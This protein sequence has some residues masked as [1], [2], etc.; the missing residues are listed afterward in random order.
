MNNRKTDQ[1]L[2]QSR[3]DDTELDEISRRFPALDRSEINEIAALCEERLNMNEKNELYENHDP[4]TVETVEVRKKTALFRHPAFTAATSF[5]ILIGTAGA[6]IAGISRKNNAETSMSAIEPPAA[7]TQITTDPEESPVVTTGSEIATQSAKNTSQ[8][9]TQTTAKVTEKAVSSVT[10]TG[11]VSD[12]KAGSVPATEG[13]VPPPTEDITDPPEGPPVEDVTEPIPDEPEDP[14]VDKTYYIEKAK[15]LREA[16]FT[17]DQLKGRNIGFDMNDTFT[18]ENGD[19]WAKVDDERFQC[20][21]DIRNLMESSM[22]TELINKQYSGY[23]GYSRLIGTDKPYYVDIDGVLYGNLTVNAAL[24]EYAT[25]YSW[26]ND[27]VTSAQEH[28][29]ETDTEYFVFTEADYTTRRQW[30]KL[31]IVLENDIW[32]LNSDQWVMITPGLSR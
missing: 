10:T 29:Y 27:E 5:I 17:I 11:I 18:A 30:R 1:L 32:K 22:T 2:R 4:D 23:T 25:N 3:F 31:G 8:K 12:P 13:A 24:D 6:V 15:E 20:T 26:V 28:I 16:L 14:G 7:V 19:I 9:K 21:D